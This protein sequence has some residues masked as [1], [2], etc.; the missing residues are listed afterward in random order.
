MSERRQAHRRESI[1]VGVRERVV[2][3]RPLP[4]MKRNDLGN[5]IMRQY[6]DMLNS[7]L[8]AYVDDRTDQK[9]SE[10]PVVPQ[11]EI[12][13]ND[14]IRDPGTVVRLGYPDYHNT[15]EDTKFFEELE[16]PEMLELIYASLDVNQLESLRELVDPNATAPE[17]NGGA[18][19]PGEDQNDTPSQPSTPGSS[20][21]GSEEATSSS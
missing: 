8:R 1:E 16:Y 14:K 2:E 19:S 13:L 4:W 3:A 9:D 17:K 5:E 15:E 20:S 21:Q 12:Y 11:L 10:S 7:T 6:S 18:N